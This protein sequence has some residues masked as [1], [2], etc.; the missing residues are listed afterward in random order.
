MVDIHKTPQKSIIQ[1]TINTIYNVKKKN[2]FKGGNNN[3]F[4]KIKGGTFDDLDP[5]QKNILNN[6]S[7]QSFFT[8]GGGGGNNNMDSLKKKYED[9]G[10]KFFDEYYNHPSNKLYK[11]IYSTRLFIIVTCLILFFATIITGVV[12]YCFCK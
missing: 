1:S 4:I 11:N 9:I 2:S 6:I 10:N 12:Y 7:S 3:N 5:V 8:G